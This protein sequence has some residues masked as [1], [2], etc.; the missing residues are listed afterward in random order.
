MNLPTELRS[1]KKDLINIKS[2]DQKCFL[3]RHVRHI[4]PAK[5]HPERITQKDKELAKELDYDDDDFPVRE[6]DFT[7]IETGNNIYINMSC[8]GNRLTFPTYVSDEKI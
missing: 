4:N 8:Y 1:P 7:K 2:K 6:K 3:W 5:L